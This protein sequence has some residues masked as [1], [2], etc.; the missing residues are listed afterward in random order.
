M[1]AIALELDVTKRSEEVTQALKSRN[2]SI[3]LSESEKARIAFLA[4]RNCIDPAV[5]NSLPPTLQGVT[6]MILE[7]KR[8]GL[9]AE[10]GIDAALGG[11]AQGAKKPLLELETVDA[12]TAA[13]MGDADEQKKVLLGI[14]EGIETEQIQPYL[15]TLHRLWVAS[16]L[17]GLSKHLH[18]V[19][20]L[21]ASAGFDDDRLFHQR[22]LKMAESVAALHAKQPVF[23]AVGSGHMIEDDGLPGLMKSK[24]FAVERVAFD[25]ASP[26]K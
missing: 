25:G 19:E 4:K 23:V 22:N 5:L 10:Y 24:G 6:L 26:G 16:D 1:N 3:T 21:A 2:V 15:K 18:S 14:L 9:F 8:D 13:L 20:A 7:A 11:F 17:D 12:Q